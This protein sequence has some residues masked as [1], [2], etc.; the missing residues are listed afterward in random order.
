MCMPMHTISFRPTK[1][2]DGDIFDQDEFQH[3]RLQSVPAVLPAVL[4]TRWD[5]VTLWFRLHFGSCPAGHSQNAAA[6]PEMWDRGSF[7]GYIPHYCRKSLEP[8]CM[9]T[10]LETRGVQNDALPALTSPF[11][12]Q[13]TL[14][15]R[16]REAE[17][18]KE[19]SFTVVSDL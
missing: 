9:S 18:G 6:A 10:E 5:S 15:R 13:I 8:W 4:Y 2:K 1:C 11:S 14:G 7:W 3:T 12:R 19:S 17:T 16:K